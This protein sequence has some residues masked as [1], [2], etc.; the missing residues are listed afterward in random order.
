MLEFD[1]RDQIVDTSTRYNLYAANSQLP[2]LP[3]RS[4]VESLANT[5]RALALLNDAVPTS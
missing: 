3:T 1:L 4:R 2:Q 5:T